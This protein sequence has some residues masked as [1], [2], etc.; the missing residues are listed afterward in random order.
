MKV[1][2]PRLAIA[3]LCALAAYAFAMMLWGSFTHHTV[4]PRGDIWLFYLLEMPLLYAGQWQELFATHNE[5]R[6]IL[7]RL[8]FLADEWLLGGTGYPIIALNC[9]LM[10]A[11]ACV[12]LAMRRW[13]DA[14][15]PLWTW[16]AVTPVL[17][18]YAQHDN[19]SYPFQISMIA[20][21]VLPLLAC[22]ALGACVNSR[23]AHV[24][25][26]V[27][28]CLGLLSVLTS[29][30][31][32]ACLF[33]LA[34]L[35]IA[36]RLG[37][38]KI[39]VFV[40]LG[41]FTSLLYLSG[42]APEI[43]GPS[44]RLAALLTSDFWGF[45]P[46]FLTGAVTDLL[47]IKGDAEATS[48]GIVLGSALLAGWAICAVRYG[49][50]GPS[51]RYA[52]VLLAML[53]YLIVSAAGAGV[54]RSFE[55]PSAALANRYATASLLAWACGLLLL[56]RHINGQTPRWM[57]LGAGSLVA[58]AA[59]LAVLDQDRAW[60]PKYDEKNEVALAV[61]S[62]ELGANDG[63]VINE[64]YKLRA[65]TDDLAAQLFDDA[66]PFFRAN[67]I[68][69]FGRP[70]FQGARETLGLPAAQSASLTCALEAV[71]HIGVMG[72]EAALR[73]VG[74]LHAPGP[75]LRLDERLYLLDGAGIVRGIGLIKRSDR[76][77]EKS[78]SWQG[79]SLNAAPSDIASV[80]IGPYACPLATMA[81]KEDQ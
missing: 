47:D 30:N 19:L 68:S 51:E 75:A 7:G 71:E 81:S 36:L 22:A 55:G 27:S 54:G 3:L 41:A 8:I 76:G 35:A 38:A 6:V 49:G 9:A 58:L 78:L 46:V 28:L 66:A 29:A 14:P 39:A 74:R 42:P 50:R 80:V 23:R 62:T 77:Q 1:H 15:A 32:L 61:L 44:S 17:F 57:R 18:S 33:V 65:A 34:A 45:V 24:W 43:D 16:V 2:L 40:A 56:A 53:G 25:F 79:Y 13:T 20:S 26:L 73:W 10:V 60:Y 52:I 48:A 63:P 31:G 72:Q 64:A 59:L 4:P 11:C 12:F 67:G 70:P 5:H 21:F 37:A 69:A